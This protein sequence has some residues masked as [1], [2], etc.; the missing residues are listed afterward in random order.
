MWHPNSLALGPSGSTA[1][2]P[3]VAECLLIADLPGSVAESVFVPT[4][5][6][7]QAFATLGHPRCRRRKHQ[8][9][10]V[11][12]SEEPSHLR[13][14]WGGRRLRP[15]SRV[16]AHRRQD[17]VGSSTALAVACSARQSLR[18]RAACS[19]S[20]GTY[21]IGSPRQQRP[22]V[23]AVGPSGRFGAS[24]N[25]RRATGPCPIWCL[26]AFT[27]AVAN[28]HHFFQSVELPGQP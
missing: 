7:P 8:G 18:A 17:H 10:L 27:E 5:R 24:Q 1:S 11:G 9:Q 26:G 23:P 13:D 6:I 12:A 25:P 16:P 22:A 19:S 20:R 28:W 4:R 3:R 2:Y 21:T 15:S 14:S